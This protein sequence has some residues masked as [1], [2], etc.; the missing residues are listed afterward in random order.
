M[1]SHQ[2]PLVNGWL[3]VQTDGLMLCCGKWKRMF[4]TLT[5]DKE[6]QI[7]SSDKVGSTPVFAGP[8]KN[9]IESYHSFAGDL[10]GSFIV[11]FTDRVVY[12]RA[13]TD[14]EMD[15]WLRHLKPIKGRNFFDK[16]A[17]GEK[18][19]E[20]MPMKEFIEG[21]KEFWY[22][23]IPTKDRTSHLKDTMAY[24]A[25][26]LDYTFC[27]KNVE[28]CQRAFDCIVE[29]AGI[30]VT[31]SNKGIDKEEVVVGMEGKPTKEYLKWKNSLKSNVKNS[32]EIDTT[33][34]KV[35]GINDLEDN[36]APRKEEQHKDEE[37]KF[38]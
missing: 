29:Q 19:S 6:F 5:Q 17:G 14:L 30:V 12:L 10:T 3:L 21:N 13:E 2:K 25:E 22:S 11:V 24:M 31:K 35:A 28:S 23:N 8:H 7:L 1:E 27:K 18:E 9:L 32:L 15:N 20:F 36:K 38:Q 4:C 37:A 16:S 33:A 26:L 34:K